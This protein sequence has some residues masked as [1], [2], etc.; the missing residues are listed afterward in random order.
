MA[1]CRPWLVA[2]IAA[3]LLLIGVFGFWQWNANRTPES[4]AAPIEDAL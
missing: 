1:K 3:A 4:S 2:L